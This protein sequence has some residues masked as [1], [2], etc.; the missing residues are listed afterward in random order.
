VALGKLLR[1][2]RPFD[3]ELFDAFIALECFEAFEGDPARTSDELKEPRDFFFRCVRKDL[4]QPQHM[5]AFRGVPFVFS[6][7]LQ[8]GKVE[9]RQAG[10]K[11]FQLVVAEDS[12]QLFGDQLVEASKEVVDLLLD[13]GVHFEVAELVEVLKLIFIRNFHVLAP[14]HKLFTLNFAKEIRVYTKVHLLS[15]NVII[16]G[17]FQASIGIVI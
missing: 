10:D 3:L 2:E 1:V 17:P 4:P 9:V 12:D 15:L 8:V 7:G 5:V 6:V 16:E 11:Q 13:H 14:R